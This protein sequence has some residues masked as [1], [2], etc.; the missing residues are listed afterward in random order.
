MSSEPETQI[1]PRS[2]RL[3]L[4]DFLA[5]PAVAYLWLISRLVSGGEFKLELEADADVE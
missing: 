2:W 3:S 5:A 1:T 4:L